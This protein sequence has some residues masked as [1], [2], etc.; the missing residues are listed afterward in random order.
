MAE[1]IFIHTVH[2]EGGHEVNG[3]DRS[4]HSLRFLFFAPIIQSSSEE[5]HLIIVTVT[6]VHSFEIG[7]IKKIG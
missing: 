3:E 1:P 2:D 4:D 6:I 7:N 5:R